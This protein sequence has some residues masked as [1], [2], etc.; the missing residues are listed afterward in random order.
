MVAVCTSFSSWLGLLRP[1]LLAHLDNTLAGGVALVV[2]PAGFGKTTLVEQY[3]ATAGTPVAR[4]RAD[5]ADGRD[6]NRTAAKLTTALRVALGRPP[7]D[8]GAPANPVAELT[9]EDLLVL[10]D[11]VDCLIGT[12]G[13]LAVERLLANRP[14]AVRIVVAGR[15]MPGLNL[16]RHEVSGRPNVIGAEH[17]RY[18]TWEV[19]R[20]LGGVYLEPL[21]PD[22][23]TVLTRR[24]G[25]WAAA[26]T[27][28]HL[29]T[30]GRPLSARRRAVAAL[31]GRWPAARDYLVRNLLGGLPGDALEFLTRTSVFNVV[32]AERC[33]RLLGTTGSNTVLDELAHRHGLPVTLDGGDAYRYHPVLRGHLAATLAEE[34]GDEES[35]RW[36]VRAAELLAAEGAYAEAL[37]AYARAGAWP[38]VTRLLARVGGEIV[39]NDHRLVEEPLPGW[40]TAEDPW[41]VYAQARRRAGDG[42]FA[43]AI[44]GYR[45]AEALFDDAEGRLRCLRERQVA[46]IWMAE[47]LPT[48]THWSAWLR[49][50][51]RRLPSAAATEAHGLD[52]VE[53]ELVRIAGELLSGNIAAATGH[54]PRPA[55]R[56][57]I[58]PAALAL[59]LLYAAIGLATGRTPAADPQVDI[60][61]DQ[62]AAEAESIGTPWLSRLARAARALGPDADAL[63]DA[64]AV[65]AECERRGDRWGYVL[66]SG[67]ACLHEQLQGKP[68]PRH[69][70]RLAAECRDLRAGVLQTWAQA[71]H[72]LAAATDRLPNAEGEVTAAAALAASTGVP[73]AQVVVTVARARLDRDRRPALRAEAQTLAASLGLPSGVLGRW[74]GDADAAP[75]PLPP[76][77]A[78]SAV[79][80]RPREAPDPRVPPGPAVTLSASD[81]DGATVIDAAPNPSA[82]PV[83]IRCFGGF[84][85]EIGGVPV[86]TSP[87][88]A[89]ARAA[90]RL[91]AMNAGRV[92]HRE[93]MI[94][95]LWPS[96][97]AAAATRNLQVTISTLRGLL[98]PGTGRGKGTL[99]LR[100]GDAYGIAVPP[101]GYADTLVFS[102]AVQR[103]NQV[104]HAGDRARELAALRA[105]LEAYA[106]DLL[107]EDGP[108]EWVVEPRE[109]FRRQATRVAGALAAAELAEGNI[110][111]AVAAA[112]HCVTLDPHDDDAWQVL[113]RAYSR[114]NAPAKAAEARR[115]YQDMLAALGLPP[116]SPGPRIPQARAPMGQAPRRP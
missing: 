95:S 114:S 35:Q 116:T 43:A 59:R 60:E 20:L 1:R 103:W 90:L 23:V 17:L 104:R 75:L 65:A 115:R 78:P 83:M 107:P 27:M 45:R 4:L 24:T 91:L 106:G 11:N 77:V 19:E 109:R 52:G 80:V 46:A 87:V 76:G 62:I 50:A 37:H 57:E 36:H 39:D 15:R 30:R 84:R 73:A 67:I 55:H 113:L 48:R 86:D 13:E 33:D 66:A 9:G 93:I 16:M 70:A 10:I 8:P 53:G 85:M 32:T 100:T 97:P 102:T 29:S 7:L 47:E 89:R 105:A 40:L 110:A 69:L 63:A 92:V 74:A 81:A 38:S 64:Y 54:R 22:D 25:G 61:L 88:R 51:T 99:L 14:P 71:F 41:L 82:P 112:E 2:A 72:A 49:A 28:F 58:T 34:I 68:D 6:D 44:D 56:L 26:L 101:G 5:P 12:A 79:V 108:A 21:P 98:E 3:A 96:L 111:A 42:Q 31:S 94:D 18:R